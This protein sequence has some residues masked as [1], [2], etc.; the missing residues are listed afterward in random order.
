MADCT[1]PSQKVKVGGIGRVRYSFAVSADDGDWERGG[2]TRGGPMTSALTFSA[3]IST[4]K[5]DGAVRNNA[6]HFFFF[7]NY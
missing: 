1:P 2:N 7:F 4:K 5:V 6:A 3:A